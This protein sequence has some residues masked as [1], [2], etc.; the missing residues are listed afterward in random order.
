MTADR[1]WEGLELPNP[2][3]VIVVRRILVADGIRAPYHSCT[4]GVPLTGVI[5]GHSRISAATSADHEKCLLTCRNAGQ[6]GC[7]ANPLAGSRKPSSTTHQA[8]AR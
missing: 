8:V 1:T 3:A 6:A 2:V 4:T 7:R 5:L